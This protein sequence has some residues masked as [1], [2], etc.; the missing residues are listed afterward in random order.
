MDQLLFNG[1]GR[2]RGRGAG[3]KLDAA[4][5]HFH[6]MTGGLK[7]FKQWNGGWLTF[8]GIAALVC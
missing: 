3:S 6:S 5:K 2:G 8:A 1:R 4:T 7:E